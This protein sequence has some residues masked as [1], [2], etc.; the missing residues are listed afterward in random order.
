MNN[1]W[2]KLTV[3]SRR[4]HESW[5]EQLAA[6]FTGQYCYVI[7]LLAKAF[8]IM[9]NILRRTSQRTAD[10]FSHRRIA[11]VFYS[12]QPTIQGCVITQASTPGD[13]QRFPPI[14]SSTEDQ[15]SSIHTQL[16]RR[17]NRFQEQSA[18]SS[19]SILGPGSITPHSFQAPLLT[20]ASP[21]NIPN[22][23]LSSR[24]CTYGSDFLYT[25]IV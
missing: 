20:Y 6:Y 17:P 11:S 10:R 14:L 13:L 12:H 5:N 9:A 3:E 19:S 2:S 23:T 15:F 18:Q 8:K 22:V 7:I 1:Y 4:Q 21:T 24:S 25:L 16:P